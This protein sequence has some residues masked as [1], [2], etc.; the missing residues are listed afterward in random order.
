MRCTVKMTVHRRIRSPLT[1][2][3]TI[4][5]KLKLFNTYNIFIANIVR[6]STILLLDIDSP[7]WV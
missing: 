4:H 3:E 1:F 7:G 2:Q 6:D 5:N